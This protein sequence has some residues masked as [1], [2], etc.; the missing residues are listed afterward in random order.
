MAP[1]AEVI[2]RDVNNTKKVKLVV[3]RIFESRRN[4]LVISDQKRSDPEWEKRLIR[5]QK[6]AVKIT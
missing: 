1:E 3:K 5:F 6:N 2:K 4:A